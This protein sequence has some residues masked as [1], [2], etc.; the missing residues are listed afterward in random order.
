[1]STDTT[2]GV[3][4]DA[5]D[6]RAEAIRAFDAKRFPKAIEHL[7]AWLEAEPNNVEAR[8]YLARAHYHRASLPLAEAES[9]RILELDPT[10]EYIM[11]LLARS[12]ER[13]SKSDEAAT[14]RRRLAAISGDDRHLQAH[15]GLAD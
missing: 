1:M 13:Q 9:R 10:N 2:S 8:E 11:L 15:E 5:V 6:Q 14:V 12:L 3:P 4:E 7:N